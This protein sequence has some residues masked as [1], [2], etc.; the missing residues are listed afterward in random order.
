[1]VNWGFADRCIIK[2][3]GRL[4]RLTAAMLVGALLTLLAVLVL[5]VHG[6]PAL[7][8]W[9]GVHLD[10]EYT[11][12]CAVTTFPGYLD[13]EQRLFS[14]LEQQV[15]DAVPP[16][17]QHRVN[18]YTRDSLSDPAR[19][20]VNWNR[21]F[22]W[23]CPN[24]DA[25]VLLL[26][27]LS[28]SPYSLRRIGRSLAD[29]GAH[30]LGLRIPGHGTVPSGLAYTSWEDMAAAVKLAMRHLKKRLPDRPV[31]IIGYSNGGALAV[32]YVLVR[33][34]DNTLP[35]VEGVV[36]ISPEIG[37]TKAAALAVWQDRLGRWLG[38]SKLAWN[39]ILPEF[40]PYKYNSFAVNAGHQAHRLTG[41][42]KRLISRYE[43]QG[44]LGKLPPI[45]AFQSAAD[46]TV[47]AQ[48][49][50]DELFNR[51][52]PSGNHEL[53]IF[54]INRHQA[55]DPLLNTRARTNITTLLKTAKP[56][57][58]RT[59]ITNIDVSG[60]KVAA[61]RFIPG[62]PES[63]MEPLHSPWPD[64]IYSLSHV[65]LP[66]AP[67]DPLYGCCPVEESPGIHLGS[68]VLRGERGVLRTEPAMLLR[69]RWNPFYDYLEQRVLT[70][71]ALP[72]EGMHEGHQ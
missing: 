6:K 54:D 49:L 27:G 61:R 59:L 69:I 28:D 71:V 1:M 22:E 40:D 3:T 13:L 66:F 24:A 64:G 67:D 23:S 50:I 47:Q 14:Q 5:V 62:D 31:F 55:F 65:A 53:V 39:D 25:G 63:R 18:R 52:P 30:V 12:D 51:L 26:H 35:P 32:H 7:K 58:R 10:A 29:N 20:P 17:D 9:H 70:F 42:I 19:W 56:S 8:V 60:S 16:Q 36:L 4:L 21:T 33:L 11:A 15:Y 45:I 38:L 44:Q 34:K 41:E 48:A 57:Y 43:K 2:F 46:A 72:S 68:V 37:I